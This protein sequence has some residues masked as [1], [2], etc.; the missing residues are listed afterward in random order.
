MKYVCDKNYCICSITSN[1]G[2]QRK[3]HVGFWPAT[4][5]KIFCCPSATELSLLYSPKE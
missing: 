4:G 5:G 3:Q 1:F 2:A